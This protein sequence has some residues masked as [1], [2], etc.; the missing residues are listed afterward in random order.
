MTLK[1]I[2]SVLL[3]FAAATAFA[4]SASA[5]DLGPRMKKLADGVYVHTGIGFDSNS[6]IYAL[7][8]L[9]VLED[10]TWV[11]RLTRSLGD[12]EAQGLTPRTP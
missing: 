8:A 7:N 2:T 12:V 9:K 3:G 5:Q 11:E 1:T 6:G 4:N 10:P